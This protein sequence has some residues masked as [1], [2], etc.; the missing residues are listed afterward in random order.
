MLTVAASIFSVSTVSLKMV[1]EKKSQGKKKKKKKKSIGNIFKGGKAGG[2]SHQI[3]QNVKSSSHLVQHLKLS[4]SQF[5]LCKLRCY[6][7]HTV[8]RFPLDSA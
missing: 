4:V 2:G 8:A 6:Q 3:T 7:S 1:Q 5:S